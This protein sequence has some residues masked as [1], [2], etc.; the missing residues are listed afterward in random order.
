MGDSHA[1]CA[2]EKVI[3]PLPQLKGALQFWRA[4]LR[5][6]TRIMTQAVGDI[7]MLKLPRC[8]RR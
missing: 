3:T 8:H 4:S 1:I 6:C 7:H 2:S 5:R